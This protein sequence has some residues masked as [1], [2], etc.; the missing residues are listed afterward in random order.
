MIDVE[1]V[2]VSELEHMRPLPDG[3]SADWTDVLRRSGLAGRSERWSWRPVLVA[4]IALAALV[5]IGV[6]IAAGFGAFNG[7]SAAQRPQT[8]AD[9]ID[10]ALL[11][12]INM[13]RK[14]VGPGAELLADSSRLIRRLP[15]GARIYTAATKDGELCVLG[16]GLDR[17]AGAMGCGP[18]LPTQSQ[19]ITLSS[20]AN[21]GTPINW[22]L[23]L[24]HITAVTFQLGGREMTVPVKNNA[25]AYEGPSP[26]VA[27]SI[28]IHYDDGSTK[29]FTP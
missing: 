22:G 4:A 1:P 19:P 24:D 3:G 18:P 12:E 29:S 8:P 11:A 5:G 16:L 13:T 23:A 9:R 15:G 27:Q 7:I 17:G 2:I 21:R 10:P 25:W 14:S 28:V 26:R 6:A 20:F